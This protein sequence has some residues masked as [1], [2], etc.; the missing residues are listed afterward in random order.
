MSPV[1]QALSDQIAKTIQLQQVAIDT[2]NASKEETA[3]VEKLT[4]DLTTSNA[5]LAI[6][7][8]GVTVP[9]AVEPP[10]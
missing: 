2:L 5:A 3:V 7:I 8:S 4:A 6:A 1:F 9:A 10:V